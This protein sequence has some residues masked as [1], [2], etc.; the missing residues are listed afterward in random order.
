MQK[1][2]NTSEDM[3]TLVHGTLAFIIAAEFMACLPAFFW[4]I[5]LYLLRVHCSYPRASKKHEFNKWS[6]KNVWNQFLQFLQQLQKKK[7][8]ISTYIPFEMK[9]LAPE[10][11]QQYSIIMLL[12]DFD[13]KG[14][15]IIKNKMK[16]LLNR[17]KK[18]MMAFP[19]VIII[20]GATI[21]I[22]M[23]KLTFASTE[24]LLL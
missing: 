18:K 23:Y 14:T 1:W 6:Y 4:S 13:R 3:S 16:V 7:E 11:W 2:R 24:K 5:V 8:G 12:V 22:R 9:L 10:F 19:S 17:Q 15:V 21:L 20:T